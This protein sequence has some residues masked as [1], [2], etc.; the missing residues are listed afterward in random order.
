MVTST[1]RK[2]RSIV[3]GVLL[4]LLGVWGGLAPFVGP[5]FHYAYTPVTAWH[6][7]QARL[8]LEI[9]P[10]GA[11]VLGGALVLA[12]TSRLLAAY[13]GILAML[14]G[15]WFAVGT[16]VNAIW[17]RLGTPGVPAGTSPTRIVLEKLG[18]FTG[19]G[20]VIVFCAALAIGR[21]SATASQTGPEADP[22]AD[23]EAGTEA[24][25]VAGKFWGDER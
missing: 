12:S 4:I 3:T 17:T 7:T 11:A 25:T 6:F 20:L 13:G 16:V 8:W 9:L 15:G 10:A 14:G 2:R 19:L 23:A 18:L 24:E 5:Y 1:I 22:D 21:A